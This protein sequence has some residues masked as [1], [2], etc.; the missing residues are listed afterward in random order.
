MDP[1]RYAHRIGADAALRADDAPRCSPPTAPTRRAGVG[2][3]RVGPHRAARPRRQRPRLGAGPARGRARRADPLQHASSG[4]AEGDDLP[5][6]FEAG[7][8]ELRRAC[9]TAMDLAATWPTWAGP[10]PGTFFPRRMAQETAVH[11]WDGAGGPSTPT[12]A[13]DGVD[14]LLELFAPRLPASGSTG[15]GGTDPPARHRRRRASGSST[16]RPDGITFEHG[17]AKGDVALRGAGGGPAAVGLEPG[18]GRR[19]VR[20]VRR[21]P[22]CS[23]PGG[24][25][26]RV[27]GDRLAERR[28]LAGRRPTRGPASRPGTASTNSAE[29]RVV[30][31]VEAQL[32]GPGRGHHRLA[33]GQVGVG[34]RDHLRRCRGRARGSPRRRPPVRSGA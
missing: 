1:D 32:A 28:A 9:S 33:L 26:R 30:D 7:A 12:L 15:V 21:P 31:R 25:G 4:A 24:H 23:R 14:E 2:R 20:G 13:V 5:D 3:P 18:A 19:P 16:S 8:A 10:Q 11:R 27:L 34:R 29:A 22:R 17:H 6:W